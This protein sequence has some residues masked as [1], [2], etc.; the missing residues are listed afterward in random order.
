MVISYLYYRNASDPSVQSGRPCSILEEFIRRGISLQKVFPLEKRESAAGWVKKAVLRSI[1]IIYRPDREPARLQSFARE[2]ARR[3]SGAP[4]DLVFSPGSECVSYLETDRPITFCADA[5]FA[6]MVDY[7][8]A[9]QGCSSDYLRKGHDQE[10]RSLT[11]ASLAIYPSEWAAKSA[12][13]HYG[14]PPEKVAVIPFGAN[15]GS[16][17]RRED[18]L[19]SI[20]Q[21]SM[22]VP[23]VLFVGTHWERK[24]GDLV[25]ETVRLLHARGL[26][27]QLD[28]VGCE[29]PPKV[30]ALPYVHAHGYLTARAPK[31][32]ETLTGLFRNAHLLFVPSRA[33][34]YGMT[35]AEASA[36]GLPSITTATGGIPGVVTDGLNGYCL[37]QEAGPA[38]YA[39]LMEGILG[40]RERYQK[41]ARDSFTQFEQRLNWPAFCDRY[42][43]LV[44]RLNGAPRV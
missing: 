41:L 27:V 44:Q 3:T 10:R 31:N 6:S 21:R 11:K 29:V 12:I 43:E 1:G 33:E 30:A 20:E 16:D 24:G 23:R 40:D 38:D 37:P 13:E 25:V 2:F 26:H 15:F 35:F 17:N 36:F 28:M 18:V 39:A 32:R 7:Y 22:K 4:F 34:A 5:T 14:T 19:A 42:L 8:W 9:Y